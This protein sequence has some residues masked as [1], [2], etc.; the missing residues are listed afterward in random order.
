MK[1]IILVVIAL[2]FTF[3]CL[4]LGQDREAYN[5]ILKYNELNRSGDFIKA[6]ETLL[7]VLN[8]KNVSSDYLLAVYNNLGVVDLTLGNYDKALEYNYKAETFIRK[9]D[10]NGQDIADIFNNRGYIFYI[11][12]S[13]DVAIDYLEKS[14][15]IYQNLDDQNQN[16]LSHLSSAYINI[17]ISYLE[18]KKYLLAL[19][20]LKKNVDLNI[21]YRLSGLPLTYLNLA[22]TYTKIGNSINAEE[23]YLKSI[24]SFKKEYGDRYYRMVDV[25]F[26]YGLLLQSQ[27]KYSE[28]LEAYRKALLI[29]RINYGEKHTFSSL[30]YK[31]VGDDYFIQ[32]KYDSSLYYYQKSLIAVVK[33]FNNPDICSNPSIDSSLFDI[34]LLDNLK[35]KAKALELFAGEQKDSAAKLKCLNC[36]LSTIDLALQLIDRIRDNYMSEESRIYLADNEKETYLF[37]THLAYSLYLLT[38]DPRMGEK[39]YSI[40]QKAEAAILR[41]EIAGNELLYST[42]VPDS[43]REEQNTLSSEIAAYSNLILDENRKII[44]DSN[45]IALWKDALFDMNREKERVAAKIE[46]VF[47]KFHDLIRKTEPDSLR[48]IQGQLKK[49][50]TIVD[51]LLSNQYADGKRKLYVFL[52]S[53]KSLKF[54][55][56]WLDSLFVRNADILRKTSNPALTGGSKVSYTA[57]TDALHYMYLNLIRPVEDQFAGNKL[58]IIPDEEIGWLSFDAF[59]KNEPA[60]GQKDYEGLH[61][62]INDYTFSYGYSSSLI[63]NK[64]RKFN[65]GA[66]VYAFAPDYDTSKAGGGAAALHGTGIEIESIYHGF[67]GIKFTG[68]EA[69]KAKFIASLKN[70]V[71]LHL[72]MH[73]MSDSTNS[74]YSYLLFDTHKEKDGKLYNYEISLKRIISPMVVLSACN[75]GT[76]TLYFGEGLMSLARSFTL[77][78]AA[79][80]IKTAWDI[81]DVASAAVMTSYYQYLSKGNEKNEAMRQAKLDYLK[82]SSPEFTHPYFWAAYQVLGDNTPVARDSHKYIIVIGI[83]IAALLVTLILLVYFKRRKIFSERSR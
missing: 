38:H 30:A 76:G 48:L 52:I 62:L 51:Y 43:L 39:M 67:S 54:N 61:Y 16:V 69:T 44:P 40:A 49:D 11:K 65:A 13:F 6:D 79:S 64:S 17:S 72:A 27:D 74:K 5:L 50:E 23:Y 73:S 18:T 42:G 9:E 4:L 53:A 47:P 36:S 25:Y 82:N 78:G 80:V 59:I 20:Y 31:H 3:H 46:T 37:A 71:I 81:N 8:I 57:Y 2:S 10:Q 77:A 33:N 83:G 35:S 45:K 66:K 26:D 55:E 58:I 22:K 19:H 63:F 60:P 15:R 1:K 68:N 14:I 12:R 34:R 21:K 70:P 41:N 56:L 28:A 29:C 7:S 24:S 32:N 75:S